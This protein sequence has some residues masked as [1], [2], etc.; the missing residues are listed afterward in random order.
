[1]DITF[2]LHSKFTLIGKLNNQTINTEP[3][4][5]RLRTRENFWVTYKIRHAALQETQYGTFGNISHTTSTAVLLFISVD[6]L[7]DKKYKVMF[8]K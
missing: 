3:L 1:M 5:K 4:R 7:Q 8:N 2:Q 6:N